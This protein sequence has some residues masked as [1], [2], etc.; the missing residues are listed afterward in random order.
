ML[1]LVDKSRDDKNEKK[2]HEKN[3][4]KK[5]VSRENKW[6]TKF[7]VYTNNFMYISFFFCCIFSE[8]YHQSFIIRYSNLSS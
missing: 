6:I 7:Q 1:N 4:S 2:K 8:Y 5:T 3:I